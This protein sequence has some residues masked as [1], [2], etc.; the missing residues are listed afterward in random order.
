MYII[1]KFIAKEW[2]K[3]LA[4]A[5]IVLFLVISIG[6]IINGFLR[7]YEVRRIFIEYFLKLPDLMG[8]M[9]SCLARAIILNLPHVG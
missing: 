3:T 5:I 9:L 2:F 1:S 6:D 4:G 7:N 8:K